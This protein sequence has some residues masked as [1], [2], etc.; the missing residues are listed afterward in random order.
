MGL[1]PLQRHMVVSTGWSMAFLCM[2][3]PS[4]RQLGVHLQRNQIKTMLGIMEARVL[5]ACCTLLADP[6]VDVLWI[7]SWW[8]PCRMY[9]MVNGWQVGR[10]YRC[11]WLAMQQV[12][13]VK[14]LLLG[15]QQQQQQQGRGGSVLIS[16]AVLV[17]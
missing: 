12:H 14:L 13:N 11:R 16:S 3:V 15:Q 4:Q 17:R 10:L 9:G 5:G 8:L 6:A 7:L 2:A 1:E